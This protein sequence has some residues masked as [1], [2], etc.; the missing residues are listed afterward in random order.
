MRTLGELQAAIPGVTSV[1]YENGFQYV[2][3]NGRTLRFGD[4]ATIDLIRQTFSGI[5][6][7]AI[8]RIKAKAL[9]AKA[10]VPEAVRSV[11][12]DLDSLIAEKDK[13][14]AKKAK[15][16]APHLEA[17]SGLHDELDGIH[18][19]LDILSNG[20]PSLDPLPESDTAVPGSRF[21]P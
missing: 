8:D 16:M 5:K 14:E 20:G 3:I 6:V 4:A 19:A 1:T 21:I 12:A 9:Q 2:T 15:A 10:I 13:L 17:I 7:S 18:T 11:E